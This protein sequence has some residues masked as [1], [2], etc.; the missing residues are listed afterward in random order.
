M[1]NILLSFVLLVF[2]NPAL[3]GG[4]AT[5]W[6]DFREARVR[7]LMLEPKPAEN[8]LQGGIEIRLLPEYKTYW[9]SPGDSGVPP[10]VD[11]SGSRGAKAFELLFPFPQRFDDGAGGEAWGYKRDVILP[12]RAERLAG[13]PLQLKLKLDFAVCGT[14]CIPLQAQFGTLSTIE[15]HPDWKEALARAHARVPRRLE[16]QQ[17]SSLLRVKEVVGGA[18]PEIALELRLDEAEKEFDLFA[19]GRAF[20][21][22]VSLERIASDRAL[23][24]LRA[25][26]PRGHSGPI[27]EIR[28]TFGSRKKALD[29]TIRLDDPLAAP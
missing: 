27:G 12:F 8:V 19:E 25:E 9:R 14:M 24:R 29:A 1:K 17:I 20:F 23:A 5:A 16:P 18:K 4:R 21:S 26:L 13:E 11:F 6:L 28:L 15:P 10:Q 3:A 7:V 22:V 2:V